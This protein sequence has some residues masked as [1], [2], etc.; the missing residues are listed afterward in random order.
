MSGSQYIALSGLRARVDELDRLAADIANVG[1]AGYKGE[2]EARASATRDTFADELQ[3]AID[4]TFGGRRL[5]TRAGAIASTGRSL[6]VAVEGPGY[7]VISTA[8]GE[9]YTRNGHFGL[10]ASRQLIAED[11]SPVQGEGGQPITV[12]EGEVRIEQ[13]GSVWAGT[14]EAGRLA[15]VEFGDPTTLTQDNASRLRAEGQAATPSTST[16]IRS[17]S[18]EQSNVSVSDRLAELTTVSR[19]FEAL[20]KAIT[21]LMNDV[22]GRA[23]DNLGRR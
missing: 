8:S 2:R 7:F 11:G 19:G 14:T 22:D 20:Q 12:G 6:D 10:S 9:R 21:M 16:F 17:G 5:D 18:L 4:T 23:I 15:V 13:D 1:T 3:T